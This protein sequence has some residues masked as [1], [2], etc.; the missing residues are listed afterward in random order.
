MAAGIP[1]ICSDFP[2][3][4]TIA[5]ESGAGVCVDPGD[6][7]G[8]RTAIQRLLKN[9]EESQTMGRKGRDYVVKNCTWSNEEKS[10]LSLY[11]TIGV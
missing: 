6:V 5:E 8:I 10:L 9:P 2:G 4:R 1:Y 7:D 11:E 3:W